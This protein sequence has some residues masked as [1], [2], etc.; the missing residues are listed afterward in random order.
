MSGYHFYGSGNFTGQ[1]VGNAVI[2]NCDIKSSKLDMDGHK[3]T[4]VAV[5]TDPYD[6]VPLIY[7]DQK[8]TTVIQSFTV[9]LTGQNVA[10]VTNL[11]MGSY[12]VLVSALVSDGPT[13]SMMIS[14]SRDAIA[15]G[16]NDL[17]SSPAATNE[18]LV[19]EWLPNSAVTLYKTGDNYDGLYS[20][21]IIG[22]P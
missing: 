22:G 1:R 20:V 21:K 8:L 5:P 3:I 7:L 17:S 6:A 13:A 15:G 9:L 4:S 12:F 10:E 2:S 16:S 18:R 19:L 14:K 11:N